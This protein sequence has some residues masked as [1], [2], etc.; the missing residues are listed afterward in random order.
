MPR[1]EL[2]FL[3]A[4]QRTCQFLCIP[5]FPRED[6]WVLV[7]LRM[8][9]RGLFPGFSQLHIKTGVGLNERS[10]TNLPQGILSVKVKFHIGVKYFHETCFYTKYTGGQTPPI[11]STLECVFI[12]Y[13]EWA[14]IRQCGVYTVGMY[15][16]YRQ[17][18]VYCRQS[19]K[20]DFASMDP[21]SRGSLVPIF[22]H[23]ADMPMMRAFLFG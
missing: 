23:D 2:V 21:G 17:W 8:S 4:F 10:S 1:G 11:C 6:L 13:T 22:S 7:Y 9:Q 15:T 3:R 20:S 16:L 12:E 14:C 19:W 18:H 5:G